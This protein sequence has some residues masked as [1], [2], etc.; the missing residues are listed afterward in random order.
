VEKE[1]EG[2]MLD[3]ITVRG[4]S[5]PVSVFELLAVKTSPRDPELAAFL[6]EYNAAIELMQQQRWG[7]ACKRLEAALSLRPNDYP[8]RIQL[9]RA[10]MYE[11]NPPPDWSGI[12]PKP[13][14]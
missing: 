7:E 14:V 4:R 1:I 2:R 5:E 13:A 11:K 10:A 9:S 6:T 8:S 3:R 12:F